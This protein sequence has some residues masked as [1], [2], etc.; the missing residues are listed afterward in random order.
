MFNIRLDT[1]EERII[2]L[3]YGSGLNHGE[4]KDGVCRK[5]LQLQKAL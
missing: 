4:K 5:D 2:G 1:S 3:E